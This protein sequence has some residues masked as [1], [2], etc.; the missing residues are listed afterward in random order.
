MHGHVSPSTSDGSSQAGKEL[1]AEVK[2]PISFSQPA[3]AD[4]MLLSSQLQY[5]QGSSQVRLYTLNLGLPEPKLSLKVFKPSK[6]LLKVMSKVLAHA[7]VYCKVVTL[8]HFFILD[9]TS[10]FLHAHTPPSFYF[11]N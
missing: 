5:T 6:M 3:Q 1:G 7:V 2:A 9:P 11:F 8:I 4:D 10:W